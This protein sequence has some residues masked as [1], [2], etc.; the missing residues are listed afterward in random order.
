MQ[1]YP[2]QKTKIIF[3]LLTDP[4]P[5]VEGVCFYGA[6]CS[7]PFNLICNKTTFR[8][9][10]PHP[11]VEDVSVGKIFATILLHEALI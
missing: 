1:H 10:D 7:I 8:P 9:F 6:L 3:D 11:R 4:I 5:G 2:F